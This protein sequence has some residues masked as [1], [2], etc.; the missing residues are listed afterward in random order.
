MALMRS[1]RNRYVAIAAAMLIYF[2]VC[3]LVLTHLVEQN[4]W[5][6]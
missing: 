1:R 2:W 3:F 6:P 5:R 4:R